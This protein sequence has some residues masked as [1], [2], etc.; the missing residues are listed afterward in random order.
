MTKGIQRRIFR[1]SATIVNLLASKITLI[2]AGID[3]TSP[4]DPIH[5]GAE[6]ELPASL[7]Y[8][9]YLN[10]LSLVEQDLQQWWIEKDTMR[11]DARTRIGSLTYW[12]LCTILLEKDLKGGRMDD[13][14]VQSS[15]RTI[16]DL[17][18]ETGDKIEF[19]NWVS[20]FH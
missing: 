7:A 5:P 11:M 14:V 1:L 6:W 12:H 15:A 9:T 10:Q 3:F 17:C 8:T 20:M 2:R 18:V 16:L 19:M 4:F 13:P